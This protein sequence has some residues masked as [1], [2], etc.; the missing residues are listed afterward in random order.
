LPASE[1]A[2]D[3]TAFKSREGPILA[4][5]RTA[6]LLDVDGTADTRDLVGDDV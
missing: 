5:R 6:D 1:V 4:K 3:M 2:N